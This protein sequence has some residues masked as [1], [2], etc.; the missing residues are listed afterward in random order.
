MCGE[1]L[2]NC[3]DAL[4]NAEPNVSQCVLGSR[5]CPEILGCV[6]G[7][8]QRELDP[9]FDQWEHDFDRGFQ[10]IKRSR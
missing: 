1:L 5:S 9:V 7:E 2:E 4:A 10:K 6:M 3:N 8:V